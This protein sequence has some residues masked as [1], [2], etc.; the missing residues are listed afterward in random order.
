MPK[1]RKSKKISSKQEEIDRLFDRKTQLLKELCKLEEQYNSLSN[2]EI[3]T[4]EDWLYGLPIESLQTL[5]A[6]GNRR[7]RLGDIRVRSELKKA[8]IKAIQEIDL[9]DQQ[10]KLA[11]FDLVSAK[12][13]FTLK[14]KADSAK[15]SSSK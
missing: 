5:N 9:I 4:A 1:I 11:S 14:A 2:T 3:K 6:D 13:A 15:N 10:I 7:S 8:S 12:I